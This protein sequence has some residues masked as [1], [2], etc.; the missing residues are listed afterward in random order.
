M[1]TSAN[2]SFDVFLSHSSEDNGRV[3]RLAERLQRAGVRVWFDEWMI[4]PGDNVYLRIEEGLNAARTLVLCL[5][6]SALES[7]WVGSERSTAQFRDPSNSAR[8]FIPLLLA[9]CDPPVTIK[10]LKHVDFREE[11]E[12]AFEELLT[13]CR[14]DP[15]PVAS[16]PIAPPPTRVA[17]RQPNYGKLVAKMCN[18]RAQEDAFRYF[19]GSHMEQSP[20]LPLCFLIQGEEGACH[21]SLV[22]RII[23][24]VE[25][26]A[27]KAYGEY[28]ATV[29]LIKVPWQYEGTV[30]ERSNQLRSVLFEKCA[31]MQ[32][33]SLL[34]LSPAALAR[35][36]SSSL[37]SFHVIQHEIRTD[38]WDR[39]TGDLLTG[40]LE[41][42]RQLPVTTPPPQI[43]LFLSVIY[44]PAEEAGRWTWMR[45]GLMLQKRKTRRIQDQLQALAPRDLPFHVLR[46]LGAITRRDVMDWFSLN[47]IYDSELRRKKC[48]QEIF[49]SAGETFTRRTM[50]EIEE[51]LTKILNDFRAEGGQV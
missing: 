6:P 50:A 32:N 47:N 11:S 29:N 31:P 3:R 4:Q 20:G 17:N 49:H 14:P 26:F 5:S 41:F 46:E 25:D 30:Q 22:L 40:Y 8:R 48:A 44:P 19:F 2:F 34:D 13:A 12:A 39:Q 16:A 36:L 38:S 24:L 45:P 15:N 10:A 51:E 35:T 7:K 42:W 33:V 43:L 37:H 23:K 21:E 9:D 1:A 27:R 18:R 28:K